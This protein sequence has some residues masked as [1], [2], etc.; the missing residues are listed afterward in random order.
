METKSKIGKVFT[1][2]LIA[3]FGMTITSESSAQKESSTDLK[4]FKITIERTHNG[5]KMQSEKNSAWIDLG[6]HLANNK[7][8]AIDEFGMTQIENVSTT[9]DPHLADFLF[10]ISIKKDQ[11][12]L[13]GFEGTAWKELSFPLEKNGKQSINQ[14]GMTE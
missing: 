6:F 10:T 8:Q 7:P 12:T 4:E 9:K 1:I 11:V 14:F 3:F 5:L 2:A 13:T